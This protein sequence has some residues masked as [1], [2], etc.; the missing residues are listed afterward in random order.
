MTG[1]E[2]REE[3]RRNALEGRVE[4]RKEQKGQ[5]GE[6][7]E[8]ERRKSRRKEKVGEEKRRRGKMAGNGRLKKGK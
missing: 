7:A 8:E 4:R 1:S 5:W 6:T 3:T 2:G